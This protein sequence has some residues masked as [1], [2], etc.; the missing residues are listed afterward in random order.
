MTYEAVEGFRLSPQQ[1][2]LA[3]YGGLDARIGATVIITGAVD[4]A[5]LRRAVDRVVD[6]HEALRTQFVQLSGGG[7]PLQVIDDEARHA[8]SVHVID[9]DGAWRVDIDASA[10]CLD[11][12]SCNTLLSDVASAYVGLDNQV[13]P[14]QYADVAEWL[15]GE[16][17]TADE[18]ARAHWAARRPPTGPL[19]GRAAQRGSAVRRLAGG[20][21]RMRR[22]A[23]AEEVLPEAIVLLAWSE[24]LRSTSLPAMPVVGVVRDGRRFSDLH[25]VVGPLESVAWARLDYAAGANAI[26]A[27]RWISEELDEATL[28]LESLPVDDP[29]LIAGFRWL[30][31]SRVVPA[32]GASFSLASIRAFEYP[33]GV[34]L[35]AQLDG[36]DLVVEVSNISA[37]EYQGAARP[38]LETLVDRVV[39][40]STAIIDAPTLPLSRHHLL[41]A[42]ETD[43]VVCRLNPC[44]D[45]SAPTPLI[46]EQVLAH[47]ASDPNSTAAVGPEGRLTYGELAARSACLAGYLAMLGA[48][49]EDVVAVI[50]DMSIAWL[51]A[52]FGVWRA[53][54]ACLAIDSTLP[55]RRA[56]SQ[57]EH[58]GARFAVVGAGREPPVPGVTVVRVHADGGV[59]HEPIGG[60][61]PHP[62]QLAFVTFTSGTTGRPKGVAVEHRNLTSYAGAMA[63]ILNTPAGA[64]FASPAGPAADLGMTAWLVALSCGASVAILPAEAMFDGHRFAAAVQRFGVDVLKITPSHLGAL[65]GSAEAGVLP[66]H[67]LVLGGERLTPELVGRVAELAPHLRVINHYG[68]T[69]TTVGALVHEA[70][71]GAPTGHDIPIGR[72]LGS[73]LA[74]PGGDGPVP[75][76]A[77]VAELWLGGPSVA[78]GY[79]GDPGTT[80]DR[81]RPDPR[82]DSVGGRAYRTGDLVRVDDDG[83]AVFAGRD[84]AQIKIRGTRV[85]LGEVER[86]LRTQPG[87]T[88][89]VA[90]ATGKG[91]DERL[92]AWITATADVEI[93]T[94]LGR[95][96]EALPEAMVPSR[97][98]VI[99]V[100]PLTASGK[101]DRQALLALR[102]PSHPAGRPPEGAVELAVAEVFEAL[103][104]DAVSDANASFFELGGHSLLATRA[105]ARLRET[106]GMAIDVETFFAD[107]TVAAVA[108][109][110]DA[111]VEARLEISRSVAGMTDEEVALALER[112]DSK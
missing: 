57:L 41:S 93:D 85:E 88:S 97:V 68:P 45:P 94:V 63:A 75:T 32:A 27:A 111:E 37:I 69:E 44:R 15:N 102:V 22:L 36:A 9:Q 14:L 42:D 86:E 92:E 52:V 43:S 5:A 49:P 96:R 84:D 100:M 90:L 26:T 50:A 104:G 34:L 2:R 87:V 76:G 91:L 16:F 70:V 20:G 80:A 65:L 59:D 53:G 110:A 33:F 35:K 18:L 98:H 77:K 6:R 103:L 54:G 8:S 64:T 30:P 89:A 105:I 7:F 1:R 21:D 66:R 47:A 79:L 24:V 74:L 108:A 13:L 23:S 12:A 48:E 106:L 109:V 60:A 56:A 38:A 46:V 61:L 3:R 67:T 82:G 28:Y 51:V 25:P 73:S 71:A 4:D 78:R 83:A 29:I 17:E 112:Q 81:F 72:A 39:R 58:V 107:P 11:A 19:P 55:H 95:I 99:N 31:E 62:M 101:P 10:M 40:L